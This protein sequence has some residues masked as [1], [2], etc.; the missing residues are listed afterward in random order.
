MILTHGGHCLVSLPSLSTFFVFSASR[1]VTSKLYQDLK[2]ARL[3]TF[4]RSPRKLSIMDR[5]LQLESSDLDRKSHIGIVGAGF[6]G[7]RCADILIRYGFRVT[8][9]EA[10]NRLG[11]RIHQQRLP[12]GCLI[13]MGANWIHGT[14]DN[15]ILDLAKETKTHTGVFDS[16][17]HVFD[18]DGKLLSAHEGEKYSTIMWNIIGEAFEY[19]EKHGAQ[20]DPNKTLLEFFEE[21][22]PKLI[23]ETQEDYERQR[24]FVL[25]MADLWGAFVGS[26]VETQSLKFFWLEECI[27]GENLFCAGTYHKI[28]ERVAKPAVDGAD[29][30]FGTQ[31]SEIHGKSTSFSE[32]VRVQTTDGQVLEF[33][34]L[35]LT[36]PLG[37]LK[38]NPQAFFPPLPDRL[39]KAIQNIGYGC[40]EKVYISFPSP[41]WLSPD[42]D[43]RKVQGFCQWLSPNYSQDTNPARWTNEIVELASLGPSSHPTLLF[44]IYGAESRHITSTLR[45]LP[46]QK[47]KLD[48]LFAFF[49]P[50]YSRLPSYDEQSP[51][52]HPTT[53]VATDWLGDDL[54]GNGSYANFQ[55]GLTEGDKD[56]E[57]MRQG[58]PREGI[59]LAGEHTAPFVALGTATGAYWSGEG[60][61]KRVAGSY[62][63]RM[64]EK[65]GKGDAITN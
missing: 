20:I 15:P 37:W 63:K 61:A 40:L 50:Y 18:E 42:A 57:I 9:L 3:H 19:S 38:R 23:P 59:W 7:L 31:V 58:V 47:E 60:V 13:D 11:G 12:N 4:D 36:T 6:A 25:Q 14:D 5:V 8:I 27:D 52:C 22:I 28:L 54:A 44:Y 64:A 10:R 16:E 53:A 2:T 55:K 26:P 39:S 41:F 17:S 56:I 21:Q 43:G 46:S 48:F 35:V 1:K 62:G 65:A 32:T 33:D 34:E 45:S 49:R 24:H 51:D 29:I 30:R